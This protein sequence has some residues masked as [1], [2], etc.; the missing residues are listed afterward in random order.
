MALPCS[1]SVFEPVEAAI[2]REGEEYLV[3]RLVKLSVAVFVTSAQLVVVSSEFCCNAKSIEGASRACDFPKQFAV[4]KKLRQQRHLLLPLPRLDP[5]PEGLPITC[6]RAERSERRS[7][8]RT[9]AMDLGPIHLLRVH[10]LRL[11]NRIAR[12]GSFDQRCGFVHHDMRDDPIVPKA[13]HTACRKLASK[14]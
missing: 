7:G 13:S 4:F 6:R 3:W 11:E 8:E 10:F 14:P 2:R 5:D 12:R 1:A 9:A